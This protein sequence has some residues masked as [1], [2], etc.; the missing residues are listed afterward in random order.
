MKRFSVKNKLLFNVV[1]LFFLS[2]YFNSY[3]QDQENYYDRK[4]DSTY[5]YRGIVPP[6]E[7]QYDLNQIFNKTLATQI[8]EDILFENNRSNI[9]LRTELMI[10]KDLEESDNIQTTSHIT[11]PLYVNY[12]ENSKFN[13][14]RYILGVAQTSAVAYMAYRHIKK[15]GFWK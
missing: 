9:W 13:M 8:P 2:T 1:I 4:T 7:F 6:I 15:Y 3:P 12:L 10:S 11:S 5:R 14:V